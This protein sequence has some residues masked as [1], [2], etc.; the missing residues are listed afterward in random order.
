MFGDRVKTWLT[1]NEPWCCAVLGYSTGEHAPGRTCSPG[2]EVY[3]AGHN[4]LLAHAQAVKVY[5]QS[6][7]KSQKGRIGLTLNTPWWE[8]HSDSEHD[9]AM[10][11]RAM[12]FHL[13]WFADPITFGDYPAV[14]KEVLKDRLPTFS[15]DEKM[16]LK[17]SI[18][19]FGLNHYSSSYAAHPTLTHVLTN[20]V[21]DYIDVFKGPTKAIKKMMNHHYFKDCGMVSINAVENGL[22]DMGWSIAPWG[23]RKLLE[24]TQQ[25][26]YPAG[27]MYLFENGMAV[28]EQNVREAAMDTKRINFMNDYLVEIH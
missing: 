13:G 18:D 15:A 7:Q 4:L 1:L 12:D 8:P 10:A 28:K 25:K 24:Y 14:M 22:T 9:V 3:R 11:N 5:R 20:A 19:F 27:G 16:L 17:G 21:S 26:Y 6:Y 23:V 2:H